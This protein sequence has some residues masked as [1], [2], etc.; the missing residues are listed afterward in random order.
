MQGWLGT[1]DKASRPAATVLIP[2]FLLLLTNCFND[3]TKERELATQQAISDREV[4]AQYVNLAVGILGRTKPPVEEGSDEDDA[5]VA[6]RTWAVA[7]L[8]LHSPVQLDAGIREALRQGE[9]DLPPVPAIDLTTIY[10]N[11]FPGL[12]SVDYSIPG[13]APG[14]LPG[15]CTVQTSIEA[16]VYDTPSAFGLSDVLLPPGQYE[17]TEFARGFDFFD[18]VGFFRIEQGW[19]TAIA[20]TPSQACFPEG[21]TN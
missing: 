5:D 20:A 7:V 6:L 8:E 4:A 13:L 11:A 3:A 18:Y 16:L 15:E 10:D 12:G 2:I 14:P 9:I 21:T 19:L 1:A 17:A